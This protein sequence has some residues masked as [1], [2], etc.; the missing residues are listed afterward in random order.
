MVNFW[1]RFEQN[2][3][4]GGHNYDRHRWPPPPV[5]YFSMASLRNSLNNDHG[6]CR[7][8]RSANKS[9]TI[10]QITFQH[11]FVGTI[12]WQ[13]YCL[14]LCF[15]RHFQVVTLHS[16]LHSTDKTSGKLLS[17]SGAAVCSSNNL[18]LRDIL[19]FQLKNK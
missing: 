11:V 19:I 13:I 6:V 18:L 3:V 14:N 1:V 17:R 15:A 16:T 4:N 8:A 7:A 5:G 2:K 9:S 10:F 12:C